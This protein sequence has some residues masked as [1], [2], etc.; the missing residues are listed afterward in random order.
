MRI[1]CIGS[2]GQVGR[3][4]AEARLPAGGRYFGVSRPDCD[5]TGPA[6]IAAAIRET[7]PDVVVNAA[8]YTLVDRAETEEAEAFAVNAEGAGNV[9]AACAEADI[10]VVHISTDYVYSGDKPSPYVETDEVNPISAYGRS[11]L[12]GERRLAALQPKHIILRSAWIFSP[13]GTNF[14]KTMLRIG[15]ERESL[16]IV[17]DQIGSP[18]YAPHLAEAIIRICEKLSD[19][20]VPAEI[21]GVYHA[22]GQGETSWC[23]LAR[24]VFERAEQLG[25]SAPD[26]AGIPTAD[27]PTPAKRP[28]N[29]RLDCTKLKEVFGISLP[30]WQDGA[31]EAVD[32]ILD[33]ESQGEARTGTGR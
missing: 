31:I 3:S 7:E 5:L 15:R 23:G 8:A 1:L 18:T 25:Q 12:A 2:S 21:W 30:R 6:S 24:A 10:P 33:L 11:K 28:A 16:R 20:S 4:L 26:V 9:G 27:Y 29:S 32:R 17:E 14:V 22:V 19:V 13:F